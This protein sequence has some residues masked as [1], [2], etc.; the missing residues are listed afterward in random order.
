MGISLSLCLPSIVVAIA[1]E[2]GRAN[3]L[4]VI[5]P[6]TDGDMAVGQPYTVLLAPRCT[7]KAVKPDLAA[8]LLDSA[9][10]NV[11]KVVRRLAAHSFF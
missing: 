5:H 1:I 3:I 9:S 8:E 11:L 2:F 10:E 6:A 4:V 7:N